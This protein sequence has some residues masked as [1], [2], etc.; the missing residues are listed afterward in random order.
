MEIKAFFINIYKI[1]Q[2]KPL[3]IRPISRSKHPFLDLEHAG[4]AGTASVFYVKVQIIYDTVW[5]NAK[6]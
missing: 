3:E 1:F 4:S 5:I 6:Q 2:S